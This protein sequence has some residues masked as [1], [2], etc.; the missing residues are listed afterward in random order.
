[1]CLLEGRGRPVLMRRLAGAFNS[2]E[3]IMRMRRVWSGCTHVHAGPSLHTFCLTPVTPLM[4]FLFTFT[5]VSYRRETILWSQ[6]RRR[7]FHYSNQHAACLSRERSGVVCWMPNWT[8]YP[9]VCGSV[10]LWPHFFFSHTVTDCMIGHS[11][12]KRCGVE[13]LQ[14]VPVKGVGSSLGLL[15]LLLNYMYHYHIIYL[16]ICL[17]MLEN[18]V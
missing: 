8:K 14:Q 9:R 4:S 17:T 11:V 10:S 2:T 6:F 16:Y 5:I 3:C 7:F 15:T 12:R 1:M 18:N 13:M